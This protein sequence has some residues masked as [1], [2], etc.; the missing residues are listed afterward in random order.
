MAK[1]AAF[2]AWAAPYPSVPPVSPGM[3]GG[4]V[5]CV[6]AILPFLKGPVSLMAYIVPLALSLLPAGAIVS[7]LPY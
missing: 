5:T 1:R 3:S 2:S 6:E 7:I 4:A